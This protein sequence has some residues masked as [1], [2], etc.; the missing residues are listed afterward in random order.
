MFRE[1]HPPVDIKSARTWTARLHWNRRELREGLSEA[2]VPWGHEQSMYHYKR[3]V[4]VL[5]TISAGLSYRDAELKFL[6]TAVNSGR[7]NFFLA[8]QYFQKTKLYVFPQ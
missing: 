6:T 4:L 2:P 1:L 5:T 7:E 3:K 8:A